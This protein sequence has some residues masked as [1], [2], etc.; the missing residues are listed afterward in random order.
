MGNRHDRLIGFAYDEAAGIAHFSM[1]VPGTAGRDRKRATVHADSHDEAVRLWSAFRSRAAEGFARPSPEAP[2]LRDF[3]TDFFPSIE[4][5]VAPKTARD[6]RYAID[7][8]LL[9][10]LGA[11]RLTDITSGVLNQLSARL[12]AKGYAGATVN[13]YV[14]V[15]ALLLSRRRGWVASLR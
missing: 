8:H 11:L 10:H 2:T 6:Y 4:A 15:A 14:N 13:N 5:N 12:K 1:Y 7:R 3:I 9:P